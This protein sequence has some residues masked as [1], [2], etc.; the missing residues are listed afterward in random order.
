MD[1]QKRLALAILLAVGMAAASPAWALNSCTGTW[2]ATPLRP[3]PDPLV[4]HLAVA[5]D[6][7]RNLDLAA[8]FNAGLRRSGVAIDGAPT[9][10]LQ[11]RVTMSGGLSEDDPVAP[12]GHSFS[13][14]GGGVQPQYPDETRIGRSRQDAPPVTVRLR[15]ELRPSPAAPV[16]WVATLQCARQG[17]D[18][19]QLAYDIGRLIGGAIGQRVDQARF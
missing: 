14:M 4:V 18:D 15:A 3:A 19:R 1:M 2:S 12:A 16:A 10:Q 6:S 17:D 11:L 9:A 8:Q 7:P 13:W 5:D